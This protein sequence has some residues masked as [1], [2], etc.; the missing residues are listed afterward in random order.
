MAQPMSRPSPVVLP[1]PGGDIIIRQFHPKDADQVHALLIEGLVY[2]RETHRD[3][4]FA[5]FPHLITFFSSGITPQHRT[6]EEPFQPHFVPRI[7]WVR[8]GVMVSLQQE[9]RP[10]NKRRRIES[11]SRRAIHLHETIHY[12]NVREILCQCASNGHGGYLSLV[13]CATLRGWCTITPAP[14]SGRILG[15]CH[16]VS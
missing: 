1:R 3:P 2:G 5:V 4:L 12:K 16:R 8:A 13:R 14:R 9:Y 15:R 6:G 10:S 7:F 11:R